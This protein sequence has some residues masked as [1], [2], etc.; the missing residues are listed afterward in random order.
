MAVGI[1][2]THA[3][4]MQEQ[5][6]KTKALHLPVEFLIAVFLVAGHRMAR[7]GGMHAYLVRATR[8]QLHLQQPLP[9]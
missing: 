8:E 3:V 1:F 9:Q 6:R 7:I 2:K 4:G 5:P